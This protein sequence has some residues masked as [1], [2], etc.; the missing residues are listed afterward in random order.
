MAATPFSICVLQL[1]FILLLMAQGC[2]LCSD[3]AILHL[4][5][6]VALLEQ[7]YHPSNGGKWTRELWQFLKNML[8]QFTIQLT[9][10]VKYPGNS[11]VPVAV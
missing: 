4:E 3:S 6:L 10:Q 2:F 8:K 1:P 5:K 7:Y 11:P 9:K